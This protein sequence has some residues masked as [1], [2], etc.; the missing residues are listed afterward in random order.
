MFTNQGRGLKQLAPD[1]P[2]LPG[3]GHWPNQG[4]PALAEG[5]RLATAIATADP[6]RF[7]TIATRKGYT[8]RFVRVAL[9]QQINKGDALLR[10]LLDRDEAAAIV[11]GER[12]DLVLITRWGQSTRFSHR[13]IEVQGTVALDL[14][15]GDQVADALSLTDEGEIL[16][17]TAS[18]RA[19][20]RS[21]QQLPA[22]A[23]PGGTQGKKLIQA[24]D[25]LAVLTYSP[26]DH[27]L[28]LSYSGKLRLV[29]TADIPLL[30]RLGQ[31]TQIVDLDHDPA[32]GVALIPRDLM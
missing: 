14:D 5:E 15:E 24:Q 27:L 13:A 4:C 12:G 17:V 26:H 25:V 1:V 16:I 19:A 30:D 3:S 23:K 31:G 28:Y 32:I 2:P 7:W 22:R 9:E 8:Q 21:T 11:D 10:S 29:S 18:G 20:R 6:P